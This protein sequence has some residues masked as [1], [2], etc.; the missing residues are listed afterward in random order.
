MENFQL[1]EEILRKACSTEKVLLEGSEIQLYPDLSPATLAYQRAMRP[2][3][4]QLQTASIRYRWCFPTGPQIAT[5]KG[6]FMVTG[7]EDLETLQ[8]ELHLTPE[9]LT[10]PNPLNFYTAGP[11]PQGLGP[12]PKECET[13]ACKRYDSRGRLT[14]PHISLADPRNTKPG[15]LPRVD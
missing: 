9:K 1:K 11:R 4:R 6:P 10:W 12:N 2:L 14:N 13:D 3:T 7:E 15:P 5:P 8:R